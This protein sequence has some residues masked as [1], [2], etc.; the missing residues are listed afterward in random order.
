MVLFS[1]ISAQTLRKKVLPR[2][3]KWLDGVIPQARAS[4]K[5]TIVEHYEDLST[6]L[7]KT[8]VEMKA[9]PVM[10][11]IEKQMNDHGIDWKRAPEPKG[12]TTSEAVMV[13]CHF[14]GGKVE[15]TQ[16]VFFTHVCA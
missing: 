12:M 1:L 5:T 10:G 9:E 16:Q 4:F 7:T 2:L 15:N 11:V 3:F 13:Q 8:F 6:D 14:F